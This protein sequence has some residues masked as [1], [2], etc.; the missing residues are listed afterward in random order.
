MVLHTGYSGIGG[1]E[2][3]FKRIYTEVNDTLKLVF[4]FTSYEYYYDP[5]PDTEYTEGYS[6]FRILE[7][8]KEFFDIETK[9]EE[10]EWEDKT[11]GAVKRFVFDGK[12]YV[13]KT[14]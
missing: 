9:S 6:E 10:T 4:D 11:S 8:S 13:E 1:H 5:Q 2:M 3:E 14:R 12:E 7:S